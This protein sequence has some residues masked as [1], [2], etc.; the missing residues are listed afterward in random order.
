M[1]DVAELSELTLCEDG[2]QLHPL[3]PE[4]VV[5]SGMWSS[6]YVHKVK[7]MF[8]LLEVQVVGSGL[9]NEGVAVTFGSREEAALVRMFY[10]GDTLTGT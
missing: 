9:R 5:F 2:A 3:T 7:P 6:E 4:T 8:G 10:Q 1:N